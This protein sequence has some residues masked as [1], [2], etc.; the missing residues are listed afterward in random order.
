MKTEKKVNDIIKS[1]DTNETSV[2]N[3]A[4]NI[5]PFS[6]DNPKTKTKR[7]NEFQKNKITLKNDNM[8]KNII[9]NEQYESIENNENNLKNIYINL[10]KKKSNINNNIII[11]NNSIEKLKHSLNILKLEKNNKKLEIVNLLSNKESLDEIYNNYIDYLKNKNRG[12]KI[13][14]KK[15][16]NIK[17]N[18]FL[19]QDE[20]A[21]EILISEIKEIDLNKF[22]EQTFNFIEEIFDNPNQQMKISLKEIINKSFSLFNNEISSSLFIDTYSVVSNFFLRISIF[23][24]NQ[25]NGKYSETIINLFLRC[26]IRMNSINVKNEKLIN[27]MN[28]KYKEDKNKIRQEIYAL[29]KKN[30]ILIKTK[31]VLDNKIK[32]LENRIKI[33][34]H[35]SHFSP[36]K[37]IKNIN[38]YK[39]SKIGVN[40]KNANNNI[41]YNEKDPK[42]QKIT[43]DNYKIENSYSKKSEIREIFKNKFQKIYKEDIVEI[44]NHHDE[45]FNENNININYEENINNITINKDSKNNDKYTPGCS[46]K[47]Y[48]TFIK[49]INNI[50]LNEKNSLNKYINI[51]ENKKVSNTIETNRQNVEKEFAGKFKF[52]A[53]GNK[54]EKIENKDIK[55]I[56]NNNNNN[57]KKYNTINFHDLSKNN[58][59]KREYISPQVN[60]K[61]QSYYKDNILNEKYLKKNNTNQKIIDRVYNNKKIKGTNNKDTKKKLNFHYYTKKI[62]NN[63]ISYNDINKNMKCDLAKKIKYLDKVNKSNSNSSTHKK[64]IKNNKDKFV[65]EQNIKYKRLLTE[66]KE[67]NFKYNFF[68][69]IQETNKKRNNSGENKFKNLNNLNNNNYRNSIKLKSGNKNN[70]NNNIKGDK[71][72]DNLIKNDYIT[73]KTK[74]Y[75]LTFEG[76]N[77][78][79]SINSTSNSKCIKNGIE[80]DNNCYNGS[81][82]SYNQFE[83]SK[84]HKINI[85]SKSKGKFQNT[86]IN[87]KQDLNTW[88]KKNI[89]NDRNQYYHCNKNTYNSG[90]KEHIK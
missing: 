64:N 52:S 6:L 73:D 60:S 54:K 66:K 75:L 77:N 25:S 53:N 11:N 86:M 20:D 2:I 59:G 26:L 1:I 28:T 27:Y 87:K 9:Y 32:E 18:P 88:S 72:Y 81:D 21:F 36:F 3:S 35:E 23:L 39:V 79:N 8:L 22:I 74:S 37:I 84:K 42:N 61:I 70:N 33:D 7:I 16:Y 30:E 45:I 19:N 17:Q 29:S 82:N 46:E 12:N 15:L 13:K 4:H 34:N 51:N 80:N 83:F 76:K 55:K 48:E 24:S 89:Y 63:I 41:V 62:N 40:E 10:Q 71:N 85:E 90:K 78:F 67:K 43:K 65:Y 49:N 56:E 31:I 69:I 5:S 57:I 58:I 68:D 47:S 38:N 14:Y 44:K 50:N